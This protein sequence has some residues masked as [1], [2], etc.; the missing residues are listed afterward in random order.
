MVQ[1]IELHHPLLLRYLAPVGS[2]V[3]NLGVYV[4]SLHPGAELAFISPCLAK[5]REFQESRMVDYNVTYRSLQRIL[6]ERNIDLDSLEE[7]EFDGGVK[8]GITTNFSSAG[9]LKESFLYHYPE[10]PASKIVR[11]TDRSYSTATWTTWRRRS[12]RRAAS[13]LLVDILSCEKG[14]TWGLDAS[15]KRLSR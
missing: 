2:P 5:R 10:I 7:S 3:Y 6:R 1:F 9:G 14:A 11:S 4:R 15:I 12:L 8:A 13:S